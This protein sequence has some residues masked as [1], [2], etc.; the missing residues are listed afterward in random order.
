M[1]TYP[2]QT[3]TMLGQLCVT[4]WYGQM[5]PDVMQP[6]FKPDTAVTPLA[7]RC[8]GLDHGTT[9]E[10]FLGTG[11]M[12]VCLKYVGITDWVREVENVSENTCQLVSSCSE[13]T[14]W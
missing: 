10:Q 14:S 7:L 11:T 4:L 9:Q 13:Y 5:W 1:P 8:S 2:G 12:V 6:G 3:R